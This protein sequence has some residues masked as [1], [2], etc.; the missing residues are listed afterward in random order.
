MSQ[1]WISRC[2]DLHALC[3]SCLCMQPWLSLTGRTVRW[4]WCCH[5]PGTGTT[6][7][8]L[9]SHK[10]AMRLCFAASARAHVSILPC[11]DVIHSSDVTAMLHDCAP[12]CLGL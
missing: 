3:Q 9:S 4:A 12:A 5:M 6:T 10:D 1:A 8:L 2:L 11:P 7:S